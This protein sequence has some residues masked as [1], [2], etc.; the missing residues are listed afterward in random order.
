MLIKIL[1]IL[2]SIIIIIIIIKINYPNSDLLSKWWFTPTI[3]FGFRS[4]LLYS[5]VSCFKTTK[6]IKL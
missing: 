5:L 1:I 4:N 6:T 2:I 3:S